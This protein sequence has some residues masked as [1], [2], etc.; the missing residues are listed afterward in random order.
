MSEPQTGESMSNAAVPSFNGKS[1]NH[2]INIPSYKLIG[3]VLT[4]T[5][6]KWGKVKKKTLP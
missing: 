1:T 4:N 5:F 3:K 2:I 6:T